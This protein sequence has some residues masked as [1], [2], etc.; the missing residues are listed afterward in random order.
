MH[1]LHEAT[2][3]RPPRPC[4]A[5]HSRRARAAGVAVTKLF[6][7]V[8]LGVLR[9]ELLRNGPRRPTAYSLA[10]CAS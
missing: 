7:G 10:S 8:Q 1:V 3:P 6:S 5:V 2:S 9:S 4:P